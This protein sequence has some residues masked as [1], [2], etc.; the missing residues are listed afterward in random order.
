MVTINFRREDGSTGQFSADEGVSLMEAAIIAGIDEVAADCGGQLSC[1][2]CHVYV[3]PS[4]YERLKP[5]IE[6]ETDMLE[7]ALK[8]QPNSRLSC[9]VVL[10]SSLDGL[11]IEL[12]ASQQ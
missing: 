11:T 5:P 12:P 10:D 6:D 9:Q 3:E 1:A 4:W 8:P 7:F 2:T